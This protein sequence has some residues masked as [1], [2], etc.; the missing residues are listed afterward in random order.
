MHNKKFL[1]IY[2][3][4]ICAFIHNYFISMRCLRVIRR[5]RILMPS[6]KRVWQKIW[7]ISQQLPNSIQKYSDY[8]CDHECMCVQVILHRDSNLL[9]FK[10]VKID[11]IAK[12]DIS[13]QGYVSCYL[14]LPYLS[15]ITNIDTPSE[16][17]S[18]FYIYS[19][20]V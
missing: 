14:I 8:P 7:C 17:I 10:C 13:N 4:L 2:S 5:E 11:L 6:N 12:F 16:S 19:F 20:T 1:D 15:K 18:W 3:F 9:Q